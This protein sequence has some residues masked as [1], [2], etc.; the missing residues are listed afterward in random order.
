MEGLRGAAVQAGTQPHPSALQQSR[1]SRALLCTWALAWCP[2]VCT[3]DSN[4]DWMVL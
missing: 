3:Y 4:I 2:I 1:C